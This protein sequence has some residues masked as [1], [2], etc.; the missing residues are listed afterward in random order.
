MR[1]KNFFQSRRPPHS[2]ASTS[3][4]TGWTSHRTR[5]WQVDVNSGALHMDVG[6]ER[7]SR[8]SGHHALSVYL[9]PPGHWMTCRQKRYFKEGM[10]RKHATYQ[11]RFIRDIQTLAGKNARQKRLVILRLATMEQKTCNGSIVNGTSGS[12]K[13][14]L[15]QHIRTVSH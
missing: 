13:T 5:I 14:F 15:T 9:S 7:D 12:I 10:P 3:L 1:L 6:L 2:S 4:T 8:E 11:Y